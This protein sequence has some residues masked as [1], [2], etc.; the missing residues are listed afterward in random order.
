MGGPAR[1]KSDFRATFRRHRIFAQR[2][3]QIVPHG[4]KMLFVETTLDY[5]IQRLPGDVIRAAR[6]ASIFRK[7]SVV[8]HFGA[9]K[10]T[11]LDRVV[12]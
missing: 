1:L 5:A 7:D 10:I 9:G 2:P 3:I 12:S 8:I 11:L 6:T 4:P